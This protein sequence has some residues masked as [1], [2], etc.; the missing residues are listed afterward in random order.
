MCP[1]C[2]ATTALM[3]AGVMSTGGLTTLAA[4]LLYLKSNTGKISSEA[5]NRKEK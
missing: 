4:R 5:Q 2:I 1:A 3:V